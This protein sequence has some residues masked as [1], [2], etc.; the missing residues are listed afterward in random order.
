MAAAVRR[1]SLPIA[2]KRELQSF[3]DTNLRGRSVARIFET[4]VELLEP[5]DDQR[6]SRS[7]FT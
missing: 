7:D 4:F 1:G 2:R 3:E 5:Q 6:D